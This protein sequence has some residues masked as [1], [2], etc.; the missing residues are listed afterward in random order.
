[1]KYEIRSR[2][3]SRRVEAEY[4]DKGTLIS[5]NFD[6]T[7]EVESVNWMLKNIPVEEPDVKRWMPQVFEVN[8]AIEQVSFEIFWDTYG[9]KVGRIAAEKQWSKLTQIERA[10][11]I[12][13]IAQYRAWCHNNT[14]PRRLK[15]PERYLSN[16]TFDD[17]LNF[18]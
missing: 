1:M 8:V 17:E 13:K 11:A 3:T 2:K 12:R 14:P 9:V 5:I 15:D 6:A 7:A 4:N 18:V 10:K 16:K